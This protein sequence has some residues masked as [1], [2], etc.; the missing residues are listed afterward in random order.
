[1]QGHVPDDLFTDD[2]HGGVELVRRRKPVS[3]N[4][5]SADRVA[6]LLV[7]ALQQR[8]E[9]GQVLRS[10]VAHHDRGGRSLPVRATSVGVVTG[11]SYLRWGGGDT[12]ELD[13]VR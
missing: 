11:S 12:P 5:G 6:L 4:R 2:R 10:P 1:M 7:R 13:A 3:S 8:Q 9:R